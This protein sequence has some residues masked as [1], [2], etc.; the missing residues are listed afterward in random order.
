MKCIGMNFQKGKIRL[1]HLNKNKGHEIEFEERDTIKI[2]PELDFCELMD[3]YK[4]DF[5]EIIDHKAPDIIAARQ[6]FDVN[7]LD[8]VKFQVSPVA[9]L[10]LIAK[11]KKVPL[12]IYSPASLRSAGPF[13]LPKGDKPLAKVDEIFG[14]H[15]P[16]W[17]DTHRTALLVAWR[18]L[19]EA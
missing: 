8:G 15:S 11:Q 1:V 3:R 6:V 14:N 19:L 2:D 17:D 12:T 13:G 7:D 4:R 5:I 16:N 9:I 18:A 10:G